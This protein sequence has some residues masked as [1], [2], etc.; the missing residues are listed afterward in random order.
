LGLLKSYFKNEAAACKI[1]RHRTARLIGFAWGKVA[2]VG[3]GVSVLESKG[4]YLFN[5][6]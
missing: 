3:V 5:R 2:S 6:N 4:N 1:T